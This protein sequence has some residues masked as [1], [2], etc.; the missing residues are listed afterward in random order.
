VQGVLQPTHS[1][2][3]KSGKDDSGDDDPEDY[4]Y[5]WLNEYLYVQRDV[6]QKKM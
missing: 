2:N 5:L 1:R 4:R 3:N 6:S